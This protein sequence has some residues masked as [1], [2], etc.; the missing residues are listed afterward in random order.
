MITVQD[1]KLCISF[2][3]H[4]IIKK[5]EDIKRCSKCDIAKELSEFSFRKDTQKYR[6]QGRDCFKLIIKE[7]RTI[8][9]HEIKIRKKEYPNNTKNLKRLYDM[10]YRERNREKIQLYE[11]I[12]F[13]NNKEELYKKTKR[14]K[15]E[16]NDFRLACNSQKRVLNAF[17]AHNVRETN[18]TFHLLG[19]SHSFLR[20][21]IES[22]LF[23]EMTLETYGKLWCLDHY[24]AVA[25][26]GKFW[27]LYH[28][29]AVASFHLL[30][31][32]GMKKCFNW[33]NLRP[34]YKK[35][36]IIKGDEID[37]RL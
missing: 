11:K 32:N 33:I 15:N 21:W 12:F 10:V 25:S 27:C 6:N 13:Q 22:Q 17:T 36:K 1:W 14:R 31:E 5:V 23:N 28:Y 20:H 24:L 3:T 35:D 37:M 16:D 4:F 7:Y 18:K 9:K 30:D 8:N 26:F 29:R 34:M 19:Y 2:Q